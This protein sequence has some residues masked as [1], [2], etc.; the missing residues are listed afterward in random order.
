MSNTDKPTEGLDQ[1]QAEVP[2]VQDELVHQ[3][4]QPEE[5]NQGDD[6]DLEEEIKPSFGELHKKPAPNKV[7]LVGKFNLGGGPSEKYDSLSFLTLDSAMA[8]DFL[9]STPE[10]AVSD[11]SGKWASAINDAATTNGVET[12]TK[13]AERPD[14][15]WSST[16]PYGGREYGPGQRQ[17]KALGG[18]KAS[19][20]AA[21]DRITAVTTGAKML[22]QPLWGS[23]LWIEVMSS[24]LDKDLT[25]DMK[26]VSDEAILGRAT[27]GRLFNMDNY[28]TINA[29]M[30][31]IYEHT[32][33]TS[34][35]DIDY[36]TFLELIRLPSIQLL[37]LA[38]AHVKF[39]TGYPY[40]HPC[41]YDITKCTHV[42]QDRVSLV[43][44]GWVDSKRI[45][46]NPENM[47]LMSRRSNVKIEEV[48][49]YQERIYSGIDSIVK[50][51]SV[52]VVLRVPTVKAFLEYANQWVAE[53]E[54]Y[55]QQAFGVNINPD[56]RNAFITSRYEANL[57][58]SYASWIDRIEIVEEGEGGIDEIVVVDNREDINEQLVVW[59]GDDVILDKI[60]SG[61][62]QYQTTAM[63]EIAAVPNFECPN[64][65]QWQK[66]T[67]GPWNSLIA[68][69]APSVL[70]YVQQSYIKAHLQARSQKR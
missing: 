2:K 9:E 69:D 47:P 62:E 64:C 16:V 33:D 70:F 61:I 52:N 24:T 34:V 22:S 29:M 53:I 56:A 31:H 8:L 12:L 30:E 68:I 42:L 41:T 57:L 37:A 5:T 15:E 67:D 60:L 3:P 58:R 49:A 23:G 44:M 27:R 26:L 17:P 36:D 21:I 43:K 7:R 4:D 40:A 10:N 50:L 63:V 19:G 59:S 65:G 66:T 18:G 28:V 25:L 38:M 54:A 35:G 20:R 1:P 32:I 39:P 55:T 45:L 6:E 46:A 48:K 13:A 11:P 51:P 14:A